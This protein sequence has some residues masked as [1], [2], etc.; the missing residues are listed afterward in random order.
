MDFYNA[1]ANSYNELHG[2]E[3]LQKFMFINNIISIK[4][5]VLDLGCGDCQLSS[6]F[7]TDYRGVEPSK[8]LVL[9][10]KFKQHFDLKN[11]QLVKAEDMILTEK[12]DIIISV[13]VA[14]HF[15]N[16]EK[17]FLHC[18]NHLKKNGVL[19]V[20]ILKNSSSYKNLLEILTSLFT[21]EEVNQGKDI[22]FICK[23][24]V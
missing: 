1:I 8:E 6:L 22:I 15:T 12:F 3:Q 16:P 11:I 17:V 18:K 20:S 2:E 7:K 21:V 19:I 9:K 4:G 5:K 24:K 13:T 14:H 10:S 23:D